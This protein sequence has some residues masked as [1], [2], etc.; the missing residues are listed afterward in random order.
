[1]KIPK[2]EKN[3][4]KGQYGKV[5]IVAGSKNYYGAPLYNA[6]GAEHSGADLI[7]LYLP[8]EHLES[9]KKY[10]LNLFLR[11]FVKGDLG[12]KDLGLILEEAE[13]N[14]VMLIGSGL[15]KNKDTMRV[16]MMILASC[17]IPLVIDAE[18]LLPE[19]LT[20]ER[21][22]PWLITPHRGEFERVFNCEATKNN[23]EQAALKHNLTILLKGPIDVIADGNNI[24]L[25]HSGCPQMRVGG[26]GDALAGI[27]ASFIAQGLNPFDAACSAAHYFGLAGE[28]FAK[29]QSFFTTYQLIKYFPKFLATVGN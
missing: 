14:H 24:H 20:I 13:H 11:E 6:L 9:A 8:K 4:H 28:S 2:R 10:S 16:I 26:T 5:L 18:A 15:G 29:K 23:V 25:N 3:S 27:V 19:I 1:M 7:T 21:K 17:E 12:L 22:A